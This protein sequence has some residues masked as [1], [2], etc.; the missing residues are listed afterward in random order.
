MPNNKSPGE[1]GIIIEFYKIFWNLIG[2][3]LHEVLVHGLE[4]EEL[5]YSQY[6][7]LIILLY[8]KGPRENIKNWRP[9][10]LLNV[11][12]KI[13]SKVLAERLKQVLPEIIHFD[14]KGCVQGRYIGEN[15]RL[16]E[17]ILH[18]IDNDELDSIILCQ[19]QEKAYDRVE[20]NWL[21]STMRY[22]GFGDKFINWI[23]TLYKN[24]KS[25]IMTNGHQSSYFNITRGIRQGDSLSALLYIIQLEPLAQKIRQDPSVE[26]IKIKLRNQNNQE[27]EI[28]GCQYVDDCNTFLKDKSNIKS[29][30]DILAKYEKVSGSKINFDKTKALAVNNLPGLPTEKIGGI[31]LIRG[32]EKALGVVIRLDD[33]S[34]L[35][36]LE[37]H[38]CQ[39]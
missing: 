23:K 29:L 33:K 31:E 36:S 5:S 17:D 9:I 30:T 2:D 25:S 18:Y 16:I 37:Q 22:F 26:G 20:W 8:K 3:D 35:Q 13:L 15:I 12:Y 14:Q 4:N 32:P 10:S 6:L 24:A 21:Y 27:I 11:D 19:D 34:N 1:D 39:S 38:Y 28:K 7:A